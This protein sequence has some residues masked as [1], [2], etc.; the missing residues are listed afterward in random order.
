[1]VDRPEAPGT[2]I[3]RRR[4]GAAVVLVAFHSYAVGA[5]LLFAT[6]W[7]LRFAGWGEVDALFFPR[8][9]GA[10][11]FVVATVYLWEWF[12]HRGVTMLL[13]TKT[14]AVVFLLALNPWRTAWSIPLS[15]L[16]DA[17]M[18][19]GMAGLHLRARREAAA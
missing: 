16:L 1:M 12:R 3:W 2:G 15:G 19:V 11:H 14:V 10:F 9:A 18:L 8:Q 4:E 6:A 7:I 13:M 5:L 17:A